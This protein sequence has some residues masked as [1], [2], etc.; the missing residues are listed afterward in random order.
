MREWKFEN[1]IEV[2][3]V[4]FDFDLHAFKV[5]NEENFLGTVFP[6]SIENME[7][8][9]EEL[10]DGKDLISGHWE[11]GRGNSCTLYGWG[12]N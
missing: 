1:G 7:S 6:D 8:M 9:I 10:D 11:D 4:E 12:S 3:E 2:Y 5:Y